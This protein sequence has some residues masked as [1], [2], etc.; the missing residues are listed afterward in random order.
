MQEQA[1][2]KPQYTEE[3]LK[4]QRAELTKFY[5]EQLPL[6]KLQKEYEEHVTAIEVAKMTRLEIMMMRAQMMKGPEEPQAKEDL[7]NKPE[8]KL[9]KVTE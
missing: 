2:E 7:Q 3:E 1:T 8:K 6:L 9:K 5:K 4:A